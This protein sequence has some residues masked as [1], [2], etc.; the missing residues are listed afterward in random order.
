MAWRI[1][2][3]VDL[4]RTI[5]DDGHMLSSPQ[6]EILTFTL[7]THAAR[8]DAWLAT[9]CPTIS[10]LAGSSSSKPVTSNSTVPPSS[11]PLLAPSDKLTCALPAPMTTEL[12]PANIPLAILYEV[13]TSLLLTSRR[14]G[15]PSCPRPCCSYACQRPAPSLRRP[16]G[17]WRRASPRHCSP[18]DK[19]TSGVLVVAKNEH[20][21]AALVA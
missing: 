15:R 8:L 4:S 12:L 14:T 5:K 2:A 17:Y 19:D 7:D 11:N 13:P 3:A 16:S 9:A 1:P 20:T 21:H 6:P 10:A 18:S